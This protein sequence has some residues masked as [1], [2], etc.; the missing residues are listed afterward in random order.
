MPEMEILNLGADA[1]ERGLVHGRHFA[2]KVAE[3]VEIY[4]RRFELAGSDRPASLLA[5]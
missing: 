1:H 2:K 3:N 4:L 5:A